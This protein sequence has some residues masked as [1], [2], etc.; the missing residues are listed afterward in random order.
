MIP[1][2]LGLI[3]LAIVMLVELIALVISFCV[4]YPIAGRVVIDIRRTATDSIYVESPKNLKDWD[5]YKALRFDVEIKHDAT[6]TP[7]PAKF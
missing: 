5:K 1:I 2:W 3:I 7:P 6:N 4:K